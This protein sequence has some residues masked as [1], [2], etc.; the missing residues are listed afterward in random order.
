MMLKDAGLCQQ[1][2]VHEHQRSVLNW[3]TQTYT[4]AKYVSL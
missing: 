1:P 2:T 4:D 3:R